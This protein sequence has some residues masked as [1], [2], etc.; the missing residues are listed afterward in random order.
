MT[1]TYPPNC[2]KLAPFDGQIW[3]ILNPIF[4]FDL[5]VGMADAIYKAFVA[6]RFGAYKSRT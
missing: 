3:P 6:A 5:Y 1:G 4:V 2:V